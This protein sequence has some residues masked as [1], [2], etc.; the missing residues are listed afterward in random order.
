MLKEPSGSRKTELLRHFGLALFRFSAVGGKT[1]LEG[2]SSPKIRSNT[3]Q[4]SPTKTSFPIEI[5]R[6][7]SLTYQTAKIC[8]NYNGHVINLLGKFI[9]NLDSYIQNGPFLLDPFPPKVDNDL[10]F[11]CS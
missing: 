6:G 1:H 10:Q 4:V 9:H 2:L 8:I 5:L 3:E 11:N 7:Y